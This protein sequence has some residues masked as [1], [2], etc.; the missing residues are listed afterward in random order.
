M[1]IAM[2]AVLGA[3]AGTDQPAGKLVA[4]PPWTGAL[5]VVASRCRM[6][7]FATRLGGVFV[8]ALRQLS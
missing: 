3:A 8:D 7:D 2:T 6:S 1:V 5:I 4:P